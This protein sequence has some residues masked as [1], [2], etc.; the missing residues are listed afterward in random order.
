MRRLYVQAKK[1]FFKVTDV[2]M[3]IGDIMDHMIIVN[4]G[5][6]EVSLHDHLHE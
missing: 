5:V 6:I 1:K 3:K 4:F 2:L